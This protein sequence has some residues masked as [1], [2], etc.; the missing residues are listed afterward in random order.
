MKRRGNWIVALA[1]L[2][3]G[4]SALGNL[5]TNI[6]EKP[7]A[8]KVGTNEYE[9]YYEGSQWASREAIWRQWDDAAKK[10]CPKGFTIKERTY[11]PTQGSTGPYI[12][13]RVRCR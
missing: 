10:A 5:A 12:S 11:H 1:V 9:I 13:G 2:L 3:G 4:C 6:L 8:T 7:T